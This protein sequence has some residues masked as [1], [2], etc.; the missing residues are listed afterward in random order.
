MNLLVALETWFVTTESLGKPRSPS[1]KKQAANR[2]GFLGAGFLHS[3]RTHLSIIAK[4][5]L[6]QCLNG[7]VFCK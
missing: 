3:L 7:T 2:K 6:K 5:K 1:R 4:E